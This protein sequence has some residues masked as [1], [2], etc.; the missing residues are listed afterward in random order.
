MTLSEDLLLGQA[1]SAFLFLT[2]FQHAKTM[3]CS[4]MFPSGPWQLL[5]TKGRH[6]SAD[7]P[8]MSLATRQAVPQLRAEAAPGENCTHRGVLRG[9]K[10]KP[11]RTSE[12]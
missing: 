7:V 12:S 4:P 8:R 3:D 2:K 10:R 6:E 9:A 5:P 11:P 1:P